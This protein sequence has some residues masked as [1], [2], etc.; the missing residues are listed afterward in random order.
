MQLIRRRG[1]KGQRGQ[2]AV[3]FMLVLPIFLFVLIAIIEFAFAFSTLNA[4]SFA[5]RDVARVGVEGG[6]RL[7]TDCSMLEGLERSFGASSD[8]SGISRVEFYWSDDKGN[9]K[10]SAVNV[11]TR[12]GNMTCT[13]VKGDTVTLPY[14]LVSATYPEASRCTVVAG[15]LAMSPPHTSV[16]TLGVQIT[17]AY[18]WKTPL[19]VFLQM[20]PTITLQSAQQMRIEPVL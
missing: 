8:R 13:T 3:E 17:Y 20:S 16:D 5:A 19:S 2:A 14:T 1:E 9:V 18:R 7:G 15:C 4:L 12:T 11:Y 10:N 6:D